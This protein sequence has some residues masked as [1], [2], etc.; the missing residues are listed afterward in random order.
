MRLGDQNLVSVL[1]GAEPE[2]YNVK[3]CIQH[4]GY[5]PFLK[6][7][8]IGLIELET[9]VKFS[10]FIRPACLTQ[11]NYLPGNVTAVKLTIQEAVNIKL[12]LLSHDPCRLGGVNLGSECK[13]LK[14]C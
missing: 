2:E 5:D 3:R 10:Q 4:E 11:V 9:E 12:F 14:N 13:H 1:D 6:E 8:D 7:N